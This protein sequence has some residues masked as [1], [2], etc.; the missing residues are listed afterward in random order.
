MEKE[1]ADRINYKCTKAAP[2]R[3]AKHKLICMF[4]AKNWNALPMKE[5]LAINVSISM[6]M[7]MHCSRAAKKTNRSI[8]CIKSGIRNKAKE[9]TV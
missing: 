4:L 5:A 7:G 6:K 1:T 2:S 3:S 8:D 9:M